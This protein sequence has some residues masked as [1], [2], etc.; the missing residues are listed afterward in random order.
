MPLD[1][2]SNS[3]AHRVEFDAARGARVKRPSVRT[4]SRALC[5]P[6]ELSQP[7][8]CLTQRDESLELLI[9]L[10]KGYSLGTCRLCISCVGIEERLIFFINLKPRVP[11]WYIAIFTRI[12]IFRVS[13]DNPHTKPRGY[14]SPSHSWTWR[15]TPTVTHLGL[16]VP[17]AS[18]RAGSFVVGVV[19]SH[20][21]EQSQPNDSSSSTQ[22]V[23][24]LLTISFGK[25]SSQ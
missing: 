18:C 22:R 10:S 4:R 12:T 6:P 23:T 16:R 1:A 8:A 7:L 19:V 11:P 9:E 17:T 13:R 2:A 25:S 14:P 20:S 15:A 3:G 24:P 5:W 21:R